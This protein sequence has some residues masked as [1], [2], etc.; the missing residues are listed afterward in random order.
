M[1]ED[2]NL[3]T[4]HHPE[5]LD[6]YWRGD[7]YDA[8][9]VTAGDVVRHETTVHAYPGGDAYGHE[10]DYHEGARLMQDL[11]HE[12][13]QWY[14]DLEAQTEHGAAEHH[15]VERHVLA[16]DG[17][18]GVP[19]PYRVAQPAHAVEHVQTVVH[20]PAAAVEV[21]GPSMYAWAAHE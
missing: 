20:E 11:E 14:H 6:S 4:V 9:H 21:E 18:Q 19:H 12:Y 16:L 2:H 5:L 1:Y 8:H 3:E 17:G 7:H 13:D 15:D 10:A